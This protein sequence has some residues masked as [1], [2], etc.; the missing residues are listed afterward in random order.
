MQIITY[1]SYTDIDICNF[2]NGS[3][4]LYNSVQVFTYVIYSNINDV[5]VHNHKSMI[6]IHDTFTSNNYQVYMFKVNI[7]VEKDISQQIKYYIFS[8]TL[9]ANDPSC[10]I[11]ASNNSVDYFEVNWYN[12][13]NNTNYDKV[14]LHLNS[15][16]DNDNEV[17]GAKVTGNIIV[18]CLC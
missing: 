17:Y 12:T 9:S 13:N 10:Y 2:I 15:Y 6:Y 18:T 4:N 1:S 7:K 8:E 14:R 11:P 16:D 3:N 5:I